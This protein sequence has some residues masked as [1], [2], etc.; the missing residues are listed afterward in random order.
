MATIQSLPTELLLK[1]LRTAAHEAQEKWIRY[2]LDNPKPVREY[3]YVGPIGVPQLKPRKR[4]PD[5]PQ[6][7]PALMVTLAQVCRRWCDVTLAHAILWAHV[8]VRDEAGTAAVLQRAGTQPLTVTF[9]LPDTEHDAA[10]RS[11]PGTRTDLFKKVLESYIGRIDTLVMPLLPELQ[12]TQF[13]SVATNLRRLLL[14][15]PSPSLIALQITEAPLLTHSAFPALTTIVCRTPLWAPLTHLCVP[16]LTTLELFRNT[17]PPM[18]DVYEVDEDYTTGLAELVR[19]L[20]RMPRLEHL[21][22]ELSEEPFDIPDTL[23]L[24]KLRSLRVRA[25]TCIC[26]ALLRCVQPP[27]HVTLDFW[28]LYGDSG[29]AVCD[30]LALPR[31]LADAFANPAQFENRFV[32]VR[33]AALCTRPHGFSL[34]GWRDAR[35]LTGTNADAPPDVHI[36]FATAAAAE[37]L[38]TILSTMPLGD[39]CSARISHLFQ[40]YG[41]PVLDCAKA[42]ATVPRLERLALECVHPCI[43]WELLAATPA[44]EIFV[45]HVPFEWA[46]ELW[47]DRAQTEHF[48]VQW[49]R[50]F[51]FSNHALEVRAVLNKRKAL[52]LKPW[53]DMRGAHYHDFLQNE[54]EPSIYDDLLSE[55]LQA[56]S[57]QKMV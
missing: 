16:T 35:A 27:P 19:A 15:E 6:P 53:V 28:C 23:A 11:A 29:P 55:L 31:A 54:A 14:I 2:L 40:G 56:D 36:H 12:V 33:S 25:A 38:R 57:S 13:A 3:T 20:A 42:F 10:A 4:T 7:A 44:T 17:P 22:V 43:A 24:P 46:D 52:G 51:E 30:V 26:A 48:E 37:D 50:T 9:R 45:E 39:A 41:E 18:E 49:K 32:S 21:A 1:I 5:D 8:D 47:G 34:C